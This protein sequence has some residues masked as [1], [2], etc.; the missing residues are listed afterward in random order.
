MIWVLDYGYNTYY[1]FFVKKTHIIHTE[2]RQFTYVGTIKCSKIYCANSC[3]FPYTDDYTIDAGNG[4][5]ILDIV[6]HTQMFCI[7]SRAIEK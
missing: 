4:E 7:M 5:K 1:T 6:K 2:N 3:L